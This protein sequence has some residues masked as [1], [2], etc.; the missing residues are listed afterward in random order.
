M[1]AMGA[2]D[3]ADWLAATDT[4]PAGNVPALA[5][6]ATYG[7]AGSASTG[8]VTSAAVGGGQP[9]EN[10]APSLAINFIICLNGTFPQQ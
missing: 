9:H 6:G 1:P 7:P 10:M 5:R 2:A 3:P 4:S 8:A